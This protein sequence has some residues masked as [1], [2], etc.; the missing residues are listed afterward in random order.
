[1]HRPQ[2]GIPLCLDDRERWRSG[3][4]YHYV[5]RSY[6]DAVDRAGGLALHLPSQ[7]DPA[8]LVAGLDGL[9]IPGGD[10]FPP[11]PATNLD[12]PLD[13]V[14]PEQLAFDEALFEAASERAIPILGICYGMQ[15]M[16]RR[17]EGILDVYLPSERP[18][19]ESHK[20]PE[21][22]RHAI[23]IEP[24]SRLAS[25][26]G[27]E[28]ANVNSLHHQAVRRVGPVHRVVA[29]TSEGVIEAIERVEDG[30]ARWE[31]GVQWHP[32][33]MREPMSERLF[34]A[35]VDQCRPSA[36]RC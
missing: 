15:L 32:E 7:S 4:A 8:A 25:I 5:D 22:E 24:T 30:S 17:R 29:Q 27:S 33:K 11:E 13:L 12:A 18:E 35:F 10:D 31:I 2:I 3:R 23:S 14:C 34:A 20:L 36:N 16:A 6:A 21:N 19:I 9:L 28:I 26:L 1:M